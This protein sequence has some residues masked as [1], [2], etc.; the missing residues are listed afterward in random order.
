ML[1]AV[2]TYISLGVCGQVAH[3]TWFMSCMQTMCVNKTYMKYYGSF[4]KT[5][6]RT[7]P[8][9]LCINIDCARL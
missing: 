2:P 3:K 7:R 5:A 9:S 6:F 8:V 4:T 1:A